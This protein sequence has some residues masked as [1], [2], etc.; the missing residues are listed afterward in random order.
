M[1]DFVRLRSLFQ[2]RMLYNDEY[3]EMTVNNRYAVKGGKSWLLQST[4]TIPK[5]I[6]RR[7][8]PRRTVRTPTVGSL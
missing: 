3:Y 1:I 8:R 5:I 6:R 2:L 4:K 7:W